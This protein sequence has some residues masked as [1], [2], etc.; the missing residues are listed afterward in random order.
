[1][2]RVTIIMMMLIMTHINQT[3]VLGK[4]FPSILQILPHLIFRTTL[5][6]FILLIIQ[7]KKLRAA[8]FKTL[9]KMT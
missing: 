4:S 6:R 3:S 5:G 8:G 7:M 2:L 1:M 9:L